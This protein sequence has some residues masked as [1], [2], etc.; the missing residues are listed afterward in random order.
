MDV[1][2][3]WFML[4]HWKISLT[5]IHIMEPSEI[6]KG[7]I[8]KTIQTPTITECWVICQKTN[9]CET[10]G[11]IAEEHSKQVGFFTCYLLGIIKNN[12]VMN[13]DKEILKI[14]ELRPFPVSQV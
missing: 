11:T 9:G 14:T 13:E 10:V 2:I 8:L 4:W 5:K 6:S 7:K 12:P 1:L 3:L